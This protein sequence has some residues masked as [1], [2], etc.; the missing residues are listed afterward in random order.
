[1]F[2]TGRL[3]IHTENHEL[4]SALFSYFALFCWFDDRY[5]ERRQALTPK[6]QSTFTGVP[7][8]YSY[9]YEP[10]YDE[11]DYGLDEVS[12]GPEF[13]TTGQTFLFNKGDT[14]R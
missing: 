6:F 8:D 9:D 7:D 14:I 4:F 5:E 1:M 3:K 13:V 11:G 12:T 10:N 2:R